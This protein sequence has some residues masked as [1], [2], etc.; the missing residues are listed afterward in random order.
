MDTIN[1]NQLTT[2]P[3]IPLRGVV[4]FP[5]LTLRLDIGRDRSIEALNHAQ[6]QDGELFLVAQRDAGA[7]DPHIEDLYSVGTVAR[8]KQVVS[9][10]DGAL[11][12]LVVGESRARM[13]EVLEKGEMQQAQLKR[14][15]S[16]IGDY[17]IELTAHL[18]VVKKLAKRFIDIKG[19][20][21]TELSA[22]IDGVE[23]ADLLCDLLGQNLLV[24]V[25]DKQQI[26]EIRDVL[27]RIQTL[28]QMLQK[29]IQ[30]HELEQSIQEKVRERIDQHQ[31]EYYLGEQ[32]KVIRSELGDEEEQEKEKLRER[33]EA[34]KMNEVAREKCQHELKRLQHISPGSPENAVS[35]NYI[36][37]LLDLPWDIISED[38]LDLSDAKKILDKDHDGLTEV[39][40][41]ILEFLAIIGLKGDLKG[42]ILCLVGPPGVGKTSIAQ[43]I[44]RAL[45]R[46]FVRLS[47]GGMRD[48]AEIR[49]HRRTYI[50]ANPGRIISGIKQAATKNPVFLLDEIDKINSDFRGD[51]AS[52]LLEV[53]DPEQNAAFS[54]NYL[55][56]PF[57]LSGVLFITTANTIDTIPRPLL[58]RMELIRVPSYTQ[59]EKADIAM[60]HLIKKQLSAHGMDR[61][62]LKISR[63][64][65][66]EV[67]DGY[68]REAGVRQLE[69]E[70]GSIIRK[71]AVKWLE[72]PKDDK[73]TISVG[74]KEVRDYL[75]V[76][77][78]L[79]DSP[80]KKPETG[81]VNGLA[82]T[83]VGGET[84][85]V[86]VACMPGSGKIDLTG[87]LGDVMKE[88][89][90][91]AYS[92]IRSK[93]DVLHIPGDFY[94]S[95]DL[96]IHVPAGAT[97]KDGPSAGVAL[98]CAMVSAITKR[99]ARQDVAMTGEVTLRGRVLPIGGV[100]EKL[101]AAHRMGITNVLLPKENEKD[102]EELPPDV[103]QALRVNFIGKVDQAINY[104]LM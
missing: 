75:G 62:K 31:K 101:L 13:L 70:L 4:V 74:P 45:G 88:S 32:L 38:K 8:V 91:A 18:R 1:D 30:M 49:G 39:K 22:S 35:R 47:L 28:A 42:P 21:S 79:S 92:Y 90:R 24:A 17:D 104:V 81:L 27:S 37:Y 68:T 3:L 86:E 96:H 77:K 95:N 43:S 16:R 12:M 2:L 33:I 76:R 97:P 7:D 64:A 15:V 73:K 6:E 57:D 48:E 40:L 36:E 14:F 80:Q 44:A 66:L 59:M 56:A 85:S 83:S 50:G 102:L 100:K 69:R 93:S 72:A 84:L 61:R 41:R 29:E 103:R 5:R 20:G 34:S 52:A 51:P 53:L 10:P 25:K 23:D 63:K 89:A 26:L 65:V 55:E 58:D 99:P 98:T 78:F 67:I 60:H 19:L 11:R 46:K 9:L 87:Q 54:D 82:W 71:A 94:K